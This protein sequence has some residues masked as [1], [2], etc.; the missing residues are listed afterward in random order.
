M[1]TGDGFAKMLKIRP[2]DSFFSN[3]CVPVVFVADN[4][5]EPVVFGAERHNW[6]PFVN[7]INEV[8]SDLFTIGIQ[9]LSLNIPKNLDALR[10]PA[11]GF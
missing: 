2:V 5:V 7:R 4:R 9:R 8:L 3:D 10:F 6:Q 1:V 11:E